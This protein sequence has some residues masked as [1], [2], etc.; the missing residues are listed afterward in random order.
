MIIENFYD[1]LI[2]AGIPVETASDDG[3][4]TFTRTLTRNELAS[5]YAIDESLLGLD[6]SAFLRSYVAETSMATIPNWAMLSPDEAEQKIIDDVDD[7][8]S[9]KLALRKL[10]YMVFALKDASHPQLRD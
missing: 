6:G 8:S 5:Y 10:A 9:A 2:A 1:K 3:Q 7:L 4:A